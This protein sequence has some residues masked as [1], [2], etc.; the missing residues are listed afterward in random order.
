MEDVGPNAF[1]RP[2]HEAIIQRLARAVDARRVDPTTAGLQNVHN[3]ADHPSVIDPRL[4]SRIGRK[5]RLKPSKLILRQP[6]TIAIHHG[7]PFRDRESQT[8]QQ[9][10]PF[11]G[12]GP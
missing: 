8:S 2:S 5:K 11:Y 12:S 10:N 1:R 6:E 7:S 3:A 9:W 4:A